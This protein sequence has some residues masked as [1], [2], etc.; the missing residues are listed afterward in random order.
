MRKTSRKRRRR[1]FEPTLTISD[2]PLAAR[3]AHTLVQYNSSNPWVMGILLVL[4]SAVSTLYIIWP[5]AYQAVNTV[6]AGIL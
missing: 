5:E 3:A 6:I 4:L 1:G 2:R